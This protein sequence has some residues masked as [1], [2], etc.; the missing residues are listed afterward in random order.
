G[1]RIAIYEFGRDGLDLEQAILLDTA[2]D[3]IPGWAALQSFSGR[4]PGDRFDLLESQLL[5][6]FYAS[7]LATFRK[8]HYGMPLALGDS[9]AAHRAR[10]AMPAILTKLDADLTESLAKGLSPG[11]LDLARDWS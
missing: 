9:S 7:H 5:G 1:A 2:R 8:Y 4:I 11:A 3:N 10:E 6:A